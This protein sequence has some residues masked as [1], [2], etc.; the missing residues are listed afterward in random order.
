MSPVCRMPW[1][2]QHE[3]HFVTRHGP[4][5]DALWYDDEQDRA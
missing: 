4:V 2:Y 1:G 5:L 3:M